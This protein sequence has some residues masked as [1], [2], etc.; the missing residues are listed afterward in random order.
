MKR[1]RKTIVPNVVSGGIAI[2]LGNNFYYMRGKKHSQGGIDIGKNPETGLEVEEG[3]VVQTTPNNIKVFSS[4]PFLNGESPAK[5]VMG[6]A[7]PDKV[8]NAQERFKNINNLNDDGTKAQ[9]GKKAKVKR[10]DF[11]KYVPVF[12]RFHDAKLM[13]QLQDSLIA[14]GFNEPQ[15]AAILSNV[16]HESGGDPKAIGP[17]GFKGLVQWGTDRY[18]K[19]ENAGKQIHYLI[20]TSLDPSSPNWTHGG[21]GKPSIK[22]AKDGYD[23]F[24]NSD[25]AYD[26]TLYYTKGFVRPAEEQA[27]INRA[28]EAVN[29]QRN[30]KE[31]GGNKNINTTMNRKSIIYTINGKGF[32]KAGYVPSM[33][34]RK[35]AKNGTIL[36]MN[37]MGEISPIS[38]VGNIK[39]ID[40]KTPN[41]YKSLR[42]YSANKTKSN[43]N[44]IGKWFKDNAFDIGTTVTD[45]LSNMASATAGYLINKK[46]LNDLQFAPEPI[47]LQAAKLK[48]IYNVNPQLDQIRESLANVEKTIMENTAS[49]KVALNRTLQARINTNEMYNKIFGNKENIETELI[50]K[51]RLNQQSVNQI[52]NERYNQYLRDKYEFNNAVLDKKSENAVSLA[53]NVNATIQNIT[54]NLNRNRQFKN[55]ILAQLLA[56]PNVD[57]RMLKAVGLPITDKTIS[58]WLKGKKEV[59]Q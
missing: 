48:T 3:E 52:N 59:T 6:G 46:M 8:F 28:K 9:F 38:L 4:V 35:K 14:R 2:P 13:E 20:E 45:V 25:N 34:E 57:P 21:G 42:D 39:P 30:M 11:D 43:S 1:T 55:T 54:E 51:D 58:D 17:G 56:A 19:T 37:I 5:L 47:P 50:N 22:T 53:N 27:R 33:G 23:K 26:A 36:P 12:D 15:R 49:S 44:A 40:Y 32:N 7:N 31:L 18:P 24:W 29:I 10:V 16:L 41:D